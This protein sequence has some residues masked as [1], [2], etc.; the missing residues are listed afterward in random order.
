MLDN[1]ILGQVV[2]AEVHGVE[3]RI[4]GDH[5]DRRDV[6]GPV[7][8]YG[9]ET[10]QEAAFQVLDLIRAEDARWSLPADFIIGR[11]EIRTRWCIA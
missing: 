11:E 10:S 2:T 8:A 5:S 4:V 3:V 1:S 7:R 9:R 6:R